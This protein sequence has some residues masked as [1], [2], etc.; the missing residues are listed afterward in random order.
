MTSTNSDRAVKLRPIPRLAAILVLVLLMTLAGIRIYAWHSLDKNTRLL[1]LVNP[2]N[3]LSETGY[4]AKLTV[5]ENG[6]LV[7]RACADSLQKMLSDCRSAGRKPVLKSAYRSVDDQLELFD[8]EVQRLV[9][10]GMSPE[11]AEAVVLRT[12]AKP[13]R[14]EHELGLAVDIVDAD[15][16]VE[17]ETQSTTPTAQWLSENAWRYG[18][19]LRYPQSAEAVTGYSWQPWHYRYVGEDAAVNISSLGITLEEY[20]SLFYSE[21]ASVEVA[22]AA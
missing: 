13:G 5:A 2:W 21:E 18:F 9:E 14:S 3:P 19:I 11:D 15:Y 12:I 16:T 17:D 10:T 6:F 7:D 4:T 20:L 1:T 22:A 8:G